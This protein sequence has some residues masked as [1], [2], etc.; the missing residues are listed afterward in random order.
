MTRTLI[1]GT[2]NLLSEDDNPWQFDPPVQQ[3]EERV[4][5]AETRRARGW[6]APSGSA[7]GSATRSQCST[8]SPRWPD[9][10]PMRAD[11]A[12]RARAFVADVCAAYGRRRDPAAP[13]FAKK[14]DLQLDNKWLPAAGRLATRSCTA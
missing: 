6:P 10:D 14:L 7:A 5:K 1:I 13:L 2:L 3:V 8:R 9:A 11:L 12:A 4:G